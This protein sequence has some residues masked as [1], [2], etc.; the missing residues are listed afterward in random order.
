MLC[1]CMEMYTVEGGGGARHVGGRQLTI[2]RRLK[3]SIGC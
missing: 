3:Y 2:V 1:V